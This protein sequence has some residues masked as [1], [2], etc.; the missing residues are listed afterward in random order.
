MR[1]DGKIQ[2]ERMAWERIRWEKFVDLQL[3]P[4]IKKHHKPTSPQKWL[5]F[6]WEK[7]K[8]VK[9]PPQRVRITKRE[10][11]VLQGIFDRLK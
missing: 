1:R 8:A 5:P 9:K 6:D 11:E 2:E 10:R 7:E 4:N 3:N